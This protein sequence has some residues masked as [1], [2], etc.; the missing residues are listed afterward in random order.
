MPA[1]LPDRRDSAAQEYDHLRAAIGHRGLMRVAVSV[2]GI[3]AWAALLLAVLVWSPVPVIALVPLVVL[4]VTFEA[5]HQLHVGAERIGRFL[6]VFYEE[7]V[8]RGPQWERVIGRFG[9]PLKGNHSDP[10][11]VAVFVMATAINALAVLLPS[12]TAQEEVVLGL[13]H[14]VVVARVVTARFAAGRQRAA[15][16]ARFRELKKTVG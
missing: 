2:A 14:A 5:V 16:E 11:F 9:R 15:D 10:I 4:I 12:P 7:D 3:S 6:L 8:E 13:V 1:D